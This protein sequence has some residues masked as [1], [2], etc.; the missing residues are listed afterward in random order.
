MARKPFRGS[1]AANV[2][3][4]GTGAINIDGCRV[5]GNRF[6]PNVSLSGDAVDMLGDKA[7]YFYCPKASKTERNAGLDL[8]PKFTATMGSGIGEREH[9]E[10]EPGA[11]NPNHHPTCKPLALCRWLCRLVTPPAGRVVDP[12]MGSGSIGLAARQEGFG[13]AGAE[14]SPDYYDIAEARLSECL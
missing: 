14:I 10:S 9:N 1:V 11:W 3:E 2:L 13:F 12:F 6:P 8:P 7:R 4:Q 5:E